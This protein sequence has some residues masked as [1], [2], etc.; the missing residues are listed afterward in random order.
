MNTSHFKNFFVFL[1]V[2]HKYIDILQKKIE[3]ADHDRMELY[4]SIV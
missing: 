2:V 3:Y 1:H 4:F